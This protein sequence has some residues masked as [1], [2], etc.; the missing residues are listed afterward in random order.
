MAPS[1]RGTCRHVGGPPA[2]SQLESQTPISQQL[3]PS[4][5]EALG[6]GWQV[7]SNQLS[8]E[9]GVYSTCQVPR[10]K[11][12]PEPS[13]SHQRDVPRVN[14]GRGG[15]LKKA[16]LLPDPAGLPDTL[17]FFPPSV[18][19]GSHLQLPDP[20]RGTEKSLS[21][22]CSGASVALGSL[23]QDLEMP[24]LPPNEVDFKSPHT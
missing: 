21:P 14:L 8:D 13:E 24:T 4:G 5:A 18:E 16:G 12:S 11:H 20:A 19:D 6:T 3:H 17:S 2:W 15:L 1:C 22:K 9:K 7:V 10:G 23:C